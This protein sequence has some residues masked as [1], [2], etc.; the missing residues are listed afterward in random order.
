MYGLAA[1]VTLV[2]GGQ[3]GPTLQKHPV[4]RVSCV[5]VLCTGTDFLLCSLLMFV[6][7]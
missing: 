6:I 5:Y 7:I 3:I 1:G 4:S 2:G